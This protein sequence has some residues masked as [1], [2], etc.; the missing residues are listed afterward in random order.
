MQKI[1]PSRPNAEHVVINSLKFFLENR[2]NLA[3]EPFAETMAQ[4]FSRR[5]LSKETQIQTPVLPWEICDG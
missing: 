3:V 5:P 2:W 1:L 4:P